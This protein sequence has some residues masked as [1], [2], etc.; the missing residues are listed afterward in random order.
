MKNFVLRVQMMNIVVYMCVTGL[1][2]Y[3]NDKTRLK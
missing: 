1:L 2:G 3:M